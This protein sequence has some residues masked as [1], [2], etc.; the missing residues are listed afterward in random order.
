MFL[1]VE[2][3]GVGD[4]GYDTLRVVD[5]VRESVRRIPV[6]D[7][8]LW[9]YIPIEFEQSPGAVT[10]PAGTEVP[11]NA[12]VLVIACLSFWAIIRSGLITR[13]LFYP[14]YFFAR[15]GG[16]VENPVALLHAFK[17]RGGLASLDALFSRC[18]RPANRNS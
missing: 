5:A 17:I 2:S 8:I 18:W 7:V 1:A 12:L 3:V 15:S 13:N 10:V 11:R 14:I 9:I 6:V 4:T 16:A